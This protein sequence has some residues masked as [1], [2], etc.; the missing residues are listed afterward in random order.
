MLSVIGYALGHLKPLLGAILAIVVV[1]YGLYLAFQSSL[2]ALQFLPSITRLIPSSLS[3]CS[4]PIIN[5]LPVC[6]GPNFAP[7]ATP[8]FEDLMKV[9]SSF[10]DILQSTAQGSVL[11]LEMKRSEASIRD[12]KYVVTYSNLPSKQELVFEFQGFIDVARQAAGDLTKFN[13]KVGRAVDQIISTNKHTLQVIDGIVESEASRS[14][15]S[16]I[17]PWSSSGL[18]QE[19]LLRQYLAH[20]GLVEEEI[21]R[22]ILEA[23]VLLRILEDLDNRLDVIHS[24]VTRDGVNV[25]DS[26]EELFASLWTKLGGNRNS[27]AKLDNQL[28]LLKSV[29]TY[30]RAA[31]S[32]VTAT[33]LKLQAVSAGLEDLRE[34]VAMPEV[35][36]TEVVPLRRHVETIQL[37]VDRLERV[38]EAARGVEGEGYR[39]VLGDAEG[40]VGKDRMVEA[41]GRVDV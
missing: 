16:K 26:R 21:Q 22:L 40:K 38:R 17:L 27:V 4:I 41:G 28:A 30:R 8:E 6:S 37:G 24:V 3:P 1:M 13:S 18:T 34:R 19:H 9:Q 25:R 33:L 5:M 36:G 35:V 10:E 39:R 31:W 2:G 15:L 29:N 14:A 20:T 23:Q 32:H 12:L 7:G 11:P